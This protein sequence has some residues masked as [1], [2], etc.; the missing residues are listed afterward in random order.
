MTHAS[1]TGRPLHFSVSPSPTSSVDACSVTGTL[2]THD[3]ARMLIWLGGDFILKLY[4]SS[5][6]PH[7]NLNQPGKSF[8]AVGGPV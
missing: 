7:V 4:C 8:H 1:S 5:E 3:R 6:S 2:E